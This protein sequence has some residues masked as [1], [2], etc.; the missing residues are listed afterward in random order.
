V[1]FYDASSAAE[2]GLAGDPETAVS[3]GM[4]IEQTAHDPSTADLGLAISSTL[5]GQKGKM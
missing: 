5:I 2:T 1:S 3:S 4:G